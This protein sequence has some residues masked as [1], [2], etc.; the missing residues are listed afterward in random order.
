[1][2]LDDG[3]LAALERRPRPDV[4]NRW[5]GHT[6]ENRGR[7]IDAA[8]RNQLILGAHIR[9][10]KPQSAPTLLPGHNRALNRIVMAEQR[11]GLVHATFAHQPAN[12][13]AADHEILVADRIDLLGAK[14]ITCTQASQHRES[15]GSIVAEEKVGANP[16][17]GHVQP[18]HQYRANERLR[19]PLR[20]LWREPDNRHA[21][22]PAARQRVELLLI[23]H[24]QRGRL[25]GPNDLRRVRIEGHRD[26]RR[27]ALFGSPTHSL[28]DLQM[29]AMHPIEIA[30]RQ[31][32][33]MPA[34]RPRIIWIVN[35]LHYR[36]I[37]KV[38]PSYANSTPAGSHAQVAACGRS[39]H[40]WVK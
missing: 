5:I 24:Q 35:D 20:K 16:D 9:R 10:R 38:R 8:R 33:L 7:R 36:A 26:G 18:L 31:S 14:A 6:V 3:L 23:G 19:V 15:A 17:F 29:T 12:T 2:R 28:D 13:G 30:E 34:G 22:H 32:R 4:G 1:M 27:A 40:M 37:S 25:I 11:A 39:W 21:V